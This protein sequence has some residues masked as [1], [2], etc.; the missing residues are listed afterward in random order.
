MLFIVPLDDDQLVC[1]VNA[2]KGV[3]QVGAQIGLN[4]CGQKFST[5]GSILGPVGEI[6]HQSGGGN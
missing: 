5:F 2:G 1:I 6:A 4:I 3:D